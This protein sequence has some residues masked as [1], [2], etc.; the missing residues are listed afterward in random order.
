MLNITSIHVPK[1]ADVLADLLREKILSGMIMEGSDLP[2]ERELGEKS[3]LSRSSVR[4]A[5]RV[6][7]G[8]GLIAKRVGR[9]GGSAV[10][11][12]TSETI[13]RS[14][15]MFIRGQ[16]I[17]LEAVLEARSAIEP[18]SAQFAAMHRTDEDIEALE[19]CHAKLELASEA[20]D[21]SAYTKANLEWHVQVVCAS[22]NEL[23]MAFISAISQSVV[24]ATELEG[25][26]SLE[27]RNAVITAHRKVMDAIKA[28]DG[29]AAARR[30]G[31]HMGA[32]VDNVKHFDKKS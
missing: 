7:E 28:K 26:N 23:L 29:E 9:N 21:L 17:R 12:P 25:F 1:A 20:G 10:M 32:Y 5:L 4:E 30:M 11:R 2:N 16:G 15:R 27:V 24:L 8:E 19:A 6:L 22:H 14:V 3:G 18:A 31:R 13:E